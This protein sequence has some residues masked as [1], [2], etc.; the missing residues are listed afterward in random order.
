MRVDPSILGGVVTRI[1]SEVYDG[2]LR[3][4]LQRLRERMKGE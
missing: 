4:R 3:G 2:S 1:G